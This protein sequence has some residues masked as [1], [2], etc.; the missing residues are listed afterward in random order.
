[1]SGLGSNAGR[2]VLWL[3]AAIAIAHAAS[4][5][6]VVPVD[7]DF[8]VYRYARNLLEHGELSFNAGAAPSDSA[9]RPRALITP[10]FA[11]NTLRVHQ[12]RSSTP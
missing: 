4:F 10:F 12:G 1:M 6:G 2:T 5:L 3:P 7:D 11:P 9:E 8:I